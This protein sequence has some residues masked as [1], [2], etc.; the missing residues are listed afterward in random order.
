MFSILIRTSNRPNY[1]DKCYE[2]VIAQ[3]FK[4]YKIFVSV[5][6]KET[7]DYVKDYPVK[8]IKVIKRADN[9]FRCPWNKYFNILLISARDWIIY[10]DDD[11]TMKPNALEEISK[12]C[13]SK[14]NVI[15]WKY[16]FLS[17]R[18]IPE[19][20]FWGKMPRRK[21]IDTGC[22]CHHKNQKVRWFPLRASDWRVIT[23]LWRKNLNFVWINKIL[24]IAGNNG[25]MGEK[26]DLNISK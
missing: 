10:L 11:V 5:D 23:Q 17:G 2:S 3:T 4:D 8:V 16:K 22:F 9:R 13:S 6:N 14:K 20:E 15:V 26:N 7:Y 25:I 1:F 19:K 12:Y 21:H 24:F 18:V